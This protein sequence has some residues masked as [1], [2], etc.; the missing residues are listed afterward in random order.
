MTMYVKTLGYEITS[1]PGMERINVEPSESSEGGIHV[2]LTGWNVSS[3]HPV[4]YGLEELN[5]LIIALQDARRLG[6]HMADEI[7]KNKE[8]A[9][10]NS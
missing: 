7:D 5:Q 2:V 8:A 1:V 10:G 4:A 6:Q 9:R 3:D